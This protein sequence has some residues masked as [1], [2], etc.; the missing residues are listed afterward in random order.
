[1]KWIVCNP[2]MVL[3]VLMTMLGAVCGSQQHPM[4]VNTPQ[5]L[6]SEVFSNMFT[7][8][9]LIDIAYCISSTSRLEEPFKCDLS[10]EKRFPNVT[11]IY[12]WYD[13]DSV[14]GYL[15]TTYSNIFNYD[16]D[17]T[18][19]KKTIILSLRGTKSLFDSYTDIKVDMVPYI[20]AGVLLPDCGPHCR[21]HR[22]F[23][24]YFLN[25]LKKID[26]YIKA[27][28]D[29]VG[30]DEEYELLILGHSLGGSISLLLGLYYLD[31]GYD[32]MTLI[33]MGQPLI[34]NEPLVNWVDDVMGSIQPVVHNEFTRKY[35]RVIH[36]DDI[37]TTIPRNGNFMERYAQF[38][39]QIY[40]NCSATREVP[41]TDQVVDCVTGDNPQCIEGDIKHSI[42]IGFDSKDYL[43]IHTTYFRSMG[44]CGI[45]V[46]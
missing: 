41:T 7:Y 35:F 11:L 33:T 37:V 25:V 17:K 9:H 46:I 6:D 4:M 10:C 23:Y 19:P 40:L 28:L 15:A 20:N 1:M 16:V 26:K 2:Y 22:G 3:G 39:N 31:L 13:S 5:V 43:R 42:G 36:K 24:D 27:E 8:A 14:C 12:Q 44:L 30:K 38:N 18:T 45:R 21:V 34:G 32:K 29:S